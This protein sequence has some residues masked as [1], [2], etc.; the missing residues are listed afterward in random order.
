MQPLPLEYFEELSV[1]M[2][3][4]APSIFFAF[5][6]PNGVYI[7]PCICPWNPLI[8]HLKNLVGVKAIVGLHFAKDYVIQFVV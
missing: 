6:V 1:Y 4:E 2:F 7:L 8:L 3:T 5:I